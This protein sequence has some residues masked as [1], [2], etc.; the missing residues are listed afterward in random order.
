MHGAA[1]KNAPPV[2]RFLH[3]NGHDIKVW[4]KENKM[5]RTPLLIAEGYRPGNFKPD[6]ATIEAI[7]EVMLAEGVEPPSGPKPIHTNY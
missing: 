6:F 2:V 4:N 5:K 1:Y 3:E 7:E